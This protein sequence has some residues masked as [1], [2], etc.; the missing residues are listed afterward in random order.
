MMRFNRPT[1]VM[2]REGEGGRA[3]GL[4]ARREHGNFVCFRRC[5]G[6]IIGGWGGGGQE[7]RDECV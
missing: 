6:K 4:E 1:G 5:K 3:G 2:L 7:R